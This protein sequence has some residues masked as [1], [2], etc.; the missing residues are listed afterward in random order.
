MPET[1]AV[2]ED[3]RVALGAAR[4]ARCGRIDFPRPPRCPACG[5]PALDERAL[6]E[7]VVHAATCVHQARPGF[8][9]P[10]WLAWI[11]LPGGARVLGRLAGAARPGDPVVP[12]V[13]P[14]RQDADGRE[15]RGLRFRVVREGR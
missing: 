6:H 11:D 15:V 2:G 4:C 8:E 1:F 7:G 10:Y 9:T 5:S 13:G 14:L 3:G 12:E